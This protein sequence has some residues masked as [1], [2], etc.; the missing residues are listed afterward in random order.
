MALLGTL[1]SN[2]IDSN[3][4]DLLGGTPHWQHLNTCNQIDIALDPF[5]FGGGTTTLDT[6]WMG[7]PLIAL[8]GQTS[9][10][11]VTA[12]ILTAAGLEHLI[13]EDKDEYK[14]KVIELAN[15]VKKLSQIRSGLRE[16]LETTAVGDPKKYVAIVEQAYREMWRRWC[17]KHCNKLEVITT[18]KQ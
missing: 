1:G 6:L 11:R 15:D 17:G 14:R 8:H 3:R 4:V 10:G 9:V 5:P 16:Q 18:S 7:V 12:G 2:G 13:A